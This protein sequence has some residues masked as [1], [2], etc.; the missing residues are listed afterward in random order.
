MIGVTGTVGKSTTCAMLHQMLVAGGRRAWLGGNIGRSLLGD[1]QAMTADDW[2]VLEM[3][4]FQ[5]AHLSEDARLPEMGVIT[6]C[7]PNHLDWH[8]SWEAYVAAKQ[9]LLSS[10]WSMDAGS[11]AATLARW[12]KSRRCSFRA[13]TTGGT[14]L[15]RPLWRRV[16]ELTKRRSPGDWPDFVD[17]RIALSSSRSLT[18][19]GFSTIRSRL[20][21]RRLARHWPRWTA[22]C[23]CW[24]GV[25]RRML[26][27]AGWPA[28]SSTRPQGAAFFGACRLKAAQGGGGRPVR[29][30][31]FAGGAGRGDRVVLAAVAAWGCDLTFAGMRELRP[32][33]R[34]SGAGRAFPRTGG[35]AGSDGGL[36]VSQNPIR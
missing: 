1:L 20:P 15:A 8:G 33:S 26:N 27:L 23:G 19:G 7:S 9:R 34:L 29:I 11:I 17:C 25:M 12:R 35:G 36:L 31:F 28:R 18:S 22:R 32:V 14:R 24:P 30:T 6:N 4:S 3:S 5:L 2:V 21:R 16:S 13:Y 10:S